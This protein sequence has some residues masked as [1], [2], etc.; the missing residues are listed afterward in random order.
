M[1]QTKKE[2]LHHQGAHVCSLETAS[3]SDFLDLQLVFLQK[4][5]VQTRGLAARLTRGWLVSW[6]KRSFNKFREESSQWQWFTKQKTCIDWTAPKKWPSFSADWTIQT[7]KTSFRWNPARNDVKLRPPELENSW[8]PNSLPPKPFQSN[9]LPTPLHPQ[10][11][12][13]KTLSPPNVPHLNL[14]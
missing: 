6:M 9:Q 10:H 13:K 4:R 11:H 8:T 12:F 2:A 5:H 3:P 1:Q 7:G 14:H